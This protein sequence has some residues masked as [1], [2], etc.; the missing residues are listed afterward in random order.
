VSV[1]WILPLLF[2]AAGALVLLGAVRQTAQAAAAL[3]T[4]CGR[5]DELRS[6]L[7]VLTAEADEVRSTL[8]GL[9]LRSEPGPTG[10]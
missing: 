2:I 6:A 10:S 7:V 5:L 9:G 8:Q 1:L 3:R 4:E